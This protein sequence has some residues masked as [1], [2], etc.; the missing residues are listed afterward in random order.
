MD[1]DPPALAGRSRRPGRASRRRRRHRVG[2]PRA[3]LVRL[4]TQLTASAP[5]E[6]LAS[7]RG[8]GSAP[9]TRASTFAD[10]RDHA[11]H[12]ATT[13]PLAASQCPA[14]C[15][16]EFVVTALRRWSPHSS[17]GCCGTSYTYSSLYPST[18][19][20]PSVHQCSSFDAIHRHAF[21]GSDAAALVPRCPGVYERGA[22]LMTM[23]TSV[24][25]VTW[26][27]TRISVGFQAFLV[28]RFLHRTIS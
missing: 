21:R 14:R 15:H 27:C 3:Q 25:W 20:H 18:N 19:A 7:H 28:L 13:R 16:A 8:S 6:S 1:R 9:P 10:G 11:A 22:S 17:Y 26:V 12:D 24:D 4:S 23:T 5:R 2:F